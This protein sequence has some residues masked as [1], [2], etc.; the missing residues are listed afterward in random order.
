MLQE[1][2][3]ARIPFL[4]AQTQENL[5]LIYR[6][7]FDKDPQPCHLDVALEA[8]DGALQEYRKANADFYIEKAERLRE[9]TL[10]AKANLTAPRP[11]VPK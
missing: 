3:R 4:W 7:L 10:P 11:P 9:T 1:R 8:V 2:T 5:A 6:A